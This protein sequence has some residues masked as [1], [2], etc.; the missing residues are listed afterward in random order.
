ME[1]EIERLFPSNPPFPP[2]VEREEDVTGCL[3]RFLVS[4]FHIRLNATAQKQNN[5]VTQLARSAR[6]AGHSK[7]AVKKNAHFSMSKL[8]GELDPNQYRRGTEWQLLQMRLLCTVF[9]L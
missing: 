7:L 8:S 1:V 9:S 4:I 3:S 5:T 6:S 2:R